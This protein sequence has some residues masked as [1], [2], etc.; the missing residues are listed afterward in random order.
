MALQYL[1][2]GAIIAFGGEKVPE[3]WELCDGK[4]VKKT[5]KKYSE[6]FLAIGTVW[7]G[8]GTPTFNLPDLRGV[9]LRGVSGD[10]LNDPE[11]NTRASPRPDI[12]GN[13]GNQG[14]NVG[15]FQNDNLRKHTHAVIDNKHSH[16]Y[17]DYTQGGPNTFEDGD[18]RGVHG[19]AQR[20]TEVSSSNIA[21]SEF[22]GVETR[23]INAYV[24]H[25]IK[26]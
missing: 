12:A 2:V 8:S 6:L 19:D 9:F 7:G 17:R 25:I 20:T 15:S 4:E 21:I 22:G 14:N 23:P 13:P 11:K 5:D 3:G 18:E 10:S 16:N 24:L 26:L 1:P